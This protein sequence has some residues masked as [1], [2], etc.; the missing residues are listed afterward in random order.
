MRKKIV[1]LIGILLIAC[2]SCLIK[3]QTAM[4]VVLKMNEVYS[5]A[6]G[7]SMNVG[8]KFYMGTN[9]VT[10]VNSFSG[11]ACKSGDS[12]YSSIMGK[13][14]I[15]NSG[16]T[17]FIDDGEK[18]IVYSKGKTAK[19]D[20]MSS[21]GI[22]D[23]SLFG[24]MAVYNF[25]KGTSDVYRIVITPTDKTVYKQIELLIN[26]GNF[27]LMGIDYYYAV[28]E[29][30]AGSIQKLSVTYSEI[31]I[32]PE[33]SSA[34]FSESVYVSRKKGNLTGVGKYAAYQVIEQD[35]T[36]PQNIIKP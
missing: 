7:Y 16:C 8:I 32:N 1:T 10:P 34:K 2:T 15:V 18:L 13:T 24:K 11:E 9:D 23:S 36:L 28:D 14:T 20:N 25:G 35:N 6:T 19:N 26:K 27:T 3:A 21:A 33:I 29:D 5:G 17:V 12:Y 4:Q 31:K 30:P 22:P